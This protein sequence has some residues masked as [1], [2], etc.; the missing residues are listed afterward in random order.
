M[1][2]RERLEARVEA[3][4]DVIRD[5]SGCE[6]VPEGCLERLRAMSFEELGQF[7][8]E[9]VRSRSVEET[10]GRFGASETAAAQ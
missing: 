4:L 5:I 10:L 6:S 9:L 8:L 1:M 3:V 7:A 2:T